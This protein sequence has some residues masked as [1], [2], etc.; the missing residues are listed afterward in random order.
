MIGPQHQLFGQCG[1][2]THLPP[3]PRQL[4]CPLFNAIFSFIFINNEIY[5]SFSLCP[6]C[7]HQIAL[8]EAAS[9]LSSRMSLPSASTLILQPHYFHLLVKLV[10][11]WNLVVIIQKQAS[12]W[13]MATKLCC[14]LLCAVWSIDER[15]AT[16]H[17][18]IV[19][20]HSL[21]T[22]H[23]KIQVNCSCILYTHLICY[24]MHVNGSNVH[25][26]MIRTWSYW[27]YCCMCYTIK[28]FLYFMIFVNF[29][30]IT[31]MNLLL[32]KRSVTM[33]TKNCSIYLLVL[34][35]NV[36]NWTVASSGKLKPTRH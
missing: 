10:S 27:V 14:S 1:S 28:G 36:L 25:Y 24:N 15:D 19:F 13:Q 17:C 29:T 35:V 12:K 23:L 30:L 18:L 22:I 8:S 20:K 3:L 11:P 4:G 32:D 21:W 6:P 5:W 16:S 2:M 34:S 26:H 31:Y 33:T 9:S 7:S